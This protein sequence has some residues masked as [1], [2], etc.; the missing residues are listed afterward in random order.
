M[1]DF[2]P[3][4]QLTTAIEDLCTLVDAPNRDGRHD[5]IRE[6]AYELRELWAAYLAQ[7]L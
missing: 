5:A 7:E 2:S 4:G 3:E 1:D 6:V